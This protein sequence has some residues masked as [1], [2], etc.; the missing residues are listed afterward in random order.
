MLLR[1]IL[2]KHLLNYRSPAGWLKGFGETNSLYIHIPKTAGTSISLCCYGEDPWHYPL[3]QYSY[4]SSRY[5]NSLYKYTFVRNP[6]SRLFSA[7]QYS[8][9]QAVEHPKTSV[10]FV[11]EFHS[12]EHFVKSWLNVDNV[13]FH[14]FFWPQCKYICDKNNDVKVDFVGKFENIEKDFEQVK[15]VLGVSQLLPKANQTL[16]HEREAYSDELAS[17]VYQVYKDDFELFG[18]DKASYIKD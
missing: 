12:F 14:Y 8:F 18:Y 10:K 15:N 3:T 7:Y 11:T 13:N 5:F 2:E 1:N 6:Y 16:G 4:L 17:I 9:K